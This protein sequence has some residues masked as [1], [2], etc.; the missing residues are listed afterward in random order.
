MF[1]KDKSYANIVYSIRRH[2]EALQFIA[3]VES[4]YSLPLFIQIALTVLLLSLL[5]YQI[6]NNMENIGGGINNY[7]YLNG[8]LLNVL[9]ENWQG[10]KIVDSSEKV[11]KSAYNTKWYNMPVTARKLLIMIMMRSEKP[12]ALKVGKIIVLS[13]VTFNA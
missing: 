4:I 8:L 3:I 9:F 10:Q 11:F 13:Y 7:V 1:T 5:G 12:S 2:T 6:I